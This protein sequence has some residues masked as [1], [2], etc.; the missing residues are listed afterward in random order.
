MA[1]DGKTSTG[2]RAQGRT[3]PSTLVSSGERTSSLA[4][5]TSRERTGAVGERSAGSKGAS[6]R[7]APASLPLPESEVVKTVTGPLAGQSTSATVV[8]PCS[9]R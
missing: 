4:P 1:T 5:D 2:A 6:K 8:P 3:R 7:Q 9:R